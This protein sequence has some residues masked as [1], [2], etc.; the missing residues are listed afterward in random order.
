VSGGQKFSGD[1]R[2]GISAKYLQKAFPSG[3]RIAA[4]SRE[5]TRWEKGR[6]KAALRFDTHD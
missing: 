5:I 4:A 2:R 1:A 6:E 3:I